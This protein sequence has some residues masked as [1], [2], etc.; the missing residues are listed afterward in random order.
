MSL[1]DGKEVSMI[2]VASAISASWTVSTITNPLWVCKTRMQLESNQTKNSVLSSFKSIVRNEGISALYKGLGASY[3]GASESVIQWVLYEKGR[4]WIRE[5]SEGNLN[6]GF[7]TFG[8]GAAV[9]LIACICTYPHEVLRTRMREGSGK[10][11]S[12]IQTSKLMM[13]EEGIRSLYGGLSVH[14]VR[15]VPHAAVLYLTYE[16]V[17]KLLQ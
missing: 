2:H 8:L 12:I 11:N 15:A 4:A 1:N 6:Q 16:T 5:N 7:L 9:K 13:K 10:Y 3:L 17:M 14:L